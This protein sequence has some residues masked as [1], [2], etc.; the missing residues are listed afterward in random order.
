MK[1]ASLG[2]TLVELLMVFVVLAI[3]VGLAAPAFKDV[4]ARWAASSALDSFVSDLRY[5]RT[6]A[7][8][9]GH[10]VTICRSGGGTG[11]AGSNGPW[12]DGWLVFDDR[13]ADGVLDTGEAVLRVQGQAAGVQLMQAPTGASA[14][15]NRYVFSSVG[16]ALGAAGSL[17][18]TAS[19]SVVGGT[20]LLCISM[21]GRASVRPVGAT[22]C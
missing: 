17:V 9:R 19:A 11:C 2:L 14:T 1:K 12:Q 3:L 22:S 21:I 10:F 16:M 4:M 8:K 20:R 13:N 7:L 18:V 5:A 15:N 6:E